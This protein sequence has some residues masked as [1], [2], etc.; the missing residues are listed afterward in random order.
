MV[1][2]VL[3][4]QSYRIKHIPEIGCSGDW[5]IIAPESDEFG[6]ASI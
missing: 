3:I 5:K 6:T 4:Q 2:I 1:G